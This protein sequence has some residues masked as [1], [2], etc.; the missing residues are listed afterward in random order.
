MN[1]RQL[2]IAYCAALAALLA[3]DALWLVVLMGPAYKVWL[4][5]LML[6][7]PK[8]LPAA[9]F[10]LL[11]TVGLVVFAVMPA[12]RKQDW[13]T[14]ALLGGLL[15]LVA[16]GTYDLSNLATL[17]G[18]PWQLTLVDMA[19]GGV[20]ACLAAVAGYMAASR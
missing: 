11:F 14:A 20:L 19:W 17:R 6:A 1:T 2:V 10:Y 16:Y 9:A 4:G 3:I 13:R 15:G 8:W 18:W 7:E 5:T 12:V